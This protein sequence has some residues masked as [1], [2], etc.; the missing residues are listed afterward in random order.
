LPA[1]E[2]RRLLP[3][4]ETVSLV[5]DRV[6]Q[7]PHGTVQRIYFPEGGVCS[8][9]RTMADGQMAG[10]AVVGCE[11][12]I[13][14]TA[15]FGGDL[16]PGETI[17]VV[18]DGAR[19]MDVKTFRREM[20]RRAALYDVVRRYGQAF[21]A[22]LLQSVACNALHPLE[23]RCARWLLDTCDRVGR[24]E[25]PL[26]QDRLAALLGVRRAS[27]TVCVGSFHRAGVVDY[28]HRRIFIRNRIALEAAS[29]ECYRVIRSY[30][31]SCFPD[32]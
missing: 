26:T 30:F 9:T 10:A 27:V 14:L 17:V 23:K 1:D 3:F 8:I 13:G 21:L 25:F 29:C 31:L 11:G 7:R 18:P 22:S 28:G 19:A 15:F 2:Y 6:V 4:L 12:L 32:P 24:N 5:R 20:E 16:D